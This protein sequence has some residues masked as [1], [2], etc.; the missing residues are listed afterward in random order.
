MKLSKKKR[1]ILAEQN[2]K[3]ELSNIKR[4]AFWD[5][6]RIYL[7]S[8]KNVPQN[9]KAFDGMISYFAKVYNVGGL[10]ASLKKYA[11]LPQ[12]TRDV[13]RE[14]LSFSDAETRQ[15]EVLKWLNSAKIHEKELKYKMECEFNKQHPYRIIDSDCIFPQDIVCNFEIF[16]KI[17]DV[18]N[19]ETFGIEKLKEYN[20]AHHPEIDAGEELEWARHYEHYKCRSSFVDRYLHDRMN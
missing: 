18:T 8:E 6:M 16:T 4:A 7:D 2:K 9:D 10:T 11:S 19:N 3:K 20:A 1:K 13:F 17:I 15:K 12:L 5:E 14:W